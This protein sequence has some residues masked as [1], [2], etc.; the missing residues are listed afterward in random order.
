MSGRFV[1]E[2][3]GTLEMRPLVQV[4]ISDSTSIDSQM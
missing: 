1:H 4:E 2:Q 3:S